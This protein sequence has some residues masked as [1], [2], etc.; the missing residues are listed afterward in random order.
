MGFWL[1]CCRLGIGTE[2]VGSVLVILLKNH[3]ESENKLV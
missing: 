3:S 1:Y 2:G